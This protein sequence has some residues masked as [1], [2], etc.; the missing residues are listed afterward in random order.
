MLRKILSGISVVVFGVQFF[1]ELT[2]L[3]AFRH[4]TVLELFEPL[5][6]LAGVR[7]GEREL[8]RNRFHMLLIKKHTVLTAPIRNL[9]SGPT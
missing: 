2:Q 8:E 5:V 9:L 7:D 4:Q 3:P 6:G 1:D